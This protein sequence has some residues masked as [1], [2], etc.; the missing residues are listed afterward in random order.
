[1][2]DIES[3][4]EITSTEN[5]RMFCEGTYPVGMELTSDIQAACLSLVSDAASQVLAYMQQPEHEDV[6]SL[7]ADLSG[8]CPSYIKDNMRNGLVRLTNSIAIDFIVPEIARE[9]LPKGAPLSQEHVFGDGSA[10]KDTARQVERQLGS[11]MIK[12]LVLDMKASDAPGY[13]LAVLHREDMVTLSIVDSAAYQNYNSILQTNAQCTPCPSSS[14]FLDLTDPSELTECVQ[15]LNTKIRGLHS[16][17]PYRSRD[18]MAVYDGHLDCHKLAYQRAQAVDAGGKA[19]GRIFD[20]LARKYT[21]SYNRRLPRAERMGIDFWKA[22]QEL[23]KTAAADNWEAKAL[24]VIDSIVFIAPPSK[25]IPKRMQAFAVELRERLDAGADTIST[26][27]WA[28]M[29]LA[30][31][32]PFNDGNGRTARLLMNAILMHG[33]Y[34]PVIIPSDNEYTAAV[35]AGAKDVSAFTNYLTE[36]VKETARYLKDGTLGFSLD[37]AV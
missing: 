11:N 29:T 12:G 24:A 25:E 5:I 33:D 14:S 13:A 18:D 20:K 17:T 23:R 19:A 37:K 8:R 16:S 26:A 21:P 2:S 34:P 3:F 10:L 30:H 22:T 6:S 27:A 28:H 36:R 4:K 35:K 9:S 1:M 15:Q 31:I 7:K 32:H